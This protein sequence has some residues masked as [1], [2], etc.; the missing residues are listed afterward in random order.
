MNFEFSRIK[1]SATRV[2]YAMAAV[3]GV[4]VLLADE[5]DDVLIETFFISGSV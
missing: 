2:F 5:N 1:P 4:R 3:Q